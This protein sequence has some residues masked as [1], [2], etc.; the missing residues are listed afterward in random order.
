ML[1]FL[2]KLFGSFWRHLRS[3]TRIDPEGGGLFG[4]LISRPEKRR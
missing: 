4:T 2:R 1:Q 3:T